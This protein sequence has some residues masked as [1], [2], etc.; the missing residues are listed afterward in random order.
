MTEANVRDEVLDTAE[1]LLHNELRARFGNSIEFGPIRV[2]HAMDWDGEPYLRAV[3]VHD[4][5]SLDKTLAR[6]LLGLMTTV[7]RRLMAEGFENPATMVP[8]YIEKV[9]LGTPCRQRVRQ[10]RRTS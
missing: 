10:S 6:R 5:N 8:S 3:I 1:Y 2:T 4:G 9:G 7:E